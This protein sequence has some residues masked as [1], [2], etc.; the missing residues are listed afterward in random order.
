MCHEELPC[1]SNAL[2]TL[3]R[4]LWEQS[5]LAMNDDATYLKN[6]VSASRA[7]FAPTGGR[8]PGKSA[9]AQA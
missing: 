7:N 3:N 6:A 9:P 5:L 8:C 1:R 2:R 4:T